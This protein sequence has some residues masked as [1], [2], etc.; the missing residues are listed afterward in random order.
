MHSILLLV[1][2][3]LTKILFTLTNKVT[4]TNK[5]APQSTVLLYH[6]TVVQAFQEIP[7]TL[8]KRNIH[9][10]AHDSPLL[11]PTLNQMNPVHST[12]TSTRSILI[13]SS[14]LCPST[15]SGLLPGGYP[16]KTQLAFLFPPYMSHATPI[17]SSLITSPKY[18]LNG[19]LG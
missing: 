15:A 2:K 1:P 11:V 14:H 10:C 16:T 18:Y 8:R 3:H 7:C 13:L 17:S 5:L 12:S 9:Y 19:G 6:L 4:L